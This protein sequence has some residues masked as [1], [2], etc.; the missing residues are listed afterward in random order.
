MATLVDY[1]VITN[2]E[3]VYEASAIPVGTYRVQVKASGFRP[4]TVDRLTTEVARTIVQDVQLEIGDIS[5]EITITSGPVTIDRA[6]TSVGHV[7]DGRTVQEAPLNGR[8]FLDLAILAPGSITASQNGF[9]T[10]P[11]RG[12]GALAINTA[13]NREETVNYLVNGITLNNLVF[14]SIEFQPSISTVQEFRMDN[15]SI[16]TEYGQSSGAVVN[17][18]TRSGSSQFHGELFEFL[19]N[20][21]L[22]ARNFFNFTT[23]EPPPFRRNQFGGAFGGPIIRSK[24]FFFFS[25][26][27]LRQLQDLSLNS[28]VLSDADRASITDAAAA[29]LAGLIPRPNFVD[30]S[31]TPRFVGS[32]PGPVNNDQWGLDISHILTASDRLHGYYSFNLSKSVEP[33]Y[34]G[35]TIPGFGHTYL[36]R[37]QFF[38]LNETHTFSPKL[39]NELRLGFNRHS[40]RIRRMPN[41]T[42][43]ISASEMGLRNGS[44]CLRS[45]LPAE[46]WTSEARRTFHQD[47]ATSPSSL[48]IA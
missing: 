31:G 1:S 11:S 26:E 44:G 19:R 32:A 23:H 33:N 43:P 27:G 22:D 2:S 25:Y 6:T 10:T 40:A 8:Y 36:I 35:N 45:T 39:I 24:T 20:N 30:S 47:G 16:S 28:V 41:S 15:S 37:R 17:V 46:P 5:Q 18:A 3:G 29:K 13:G 21:A 12:L 38:S 14:S 4:Y 42:P 9:S 7:I 34:F 48:E